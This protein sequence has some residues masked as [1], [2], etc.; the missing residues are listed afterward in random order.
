M[1][2][3]VVVVVAPMAAAAIPAPA[4]DAVAP[5]GVEEE[6]EVSLEESFLALA[7]PILDQLFQSVQVRQ[8]LPSGP[9][10]MPGGRGVLASGA[11]DDAEVEG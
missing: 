5:D 1:A 9:R 2:L 4:I 10:T 3:A 11:E 7:L 6:E 8:G